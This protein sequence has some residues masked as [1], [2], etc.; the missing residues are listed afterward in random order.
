MGLILATATLALL[1]L[2]ILVAVTLHDLRSADLLADA[3]LHEPLRIYSSDGLLIGEYGVERRHYTDLATMPPCLVQAFLAAEDSR[4]FQHE[5]IDV[6]GLARAALSYLRTGEPTQGGSTITMQMVRNVYLTSEKTFDRK[7]AEILLAWHLERTLTK[8]EILAIYLNK[9]FFGHRAYGVAA[10]AQ[11]YYDKPLAELTLAEAAMLAGIPKAPSTNNPVTNPERALVR[12]DYVLGRMLALGDIDEEAYREARESPDRTRLHRRELG[13]EAGY[14]AEMARQEMVRRYG[15]EA[16]RAGYRVTTSIDSAH[17]RSA[18]AAV[19]DALLAY[20]RRHGYR[21]PERRVDL[22]EAAGED[23]DVLI[24]KALGE[25]GPI[26]GLTAAVVLQVQRD[27]AQVSIGH[28]QRLEL[29][30]EAIRWARPFRD[31]DRRGPA[32]KAVTDVLTVGDLIRLERTEA[33]AWMLAQRSRVS[34]ALVSVS[35]LDGAILALVGGSA[36]EESQFNRAS[37]ARRPAGSSFKPFLYAAA[38]ERGWTPA[39][40]VRD[41]SVAVR[42]SAR[43]VWRPGNADGKT[44]G[45]IRLRPALVQSRNLAAIDLLDQIGLD[46]AI[47]FVGRFGFD[48][49]RMPRGLSLALGSAEVSP[50]KMA[51]A[52][53]VFANGGYWVVPHLIRRIEGP[54]GHLLFEADPVRACQG[55]WFREPDADPRLDALPRGREAERVIS[56]PVAYQMHSMLADVI[57]NGTGRRARALK[58]ADIAGKTGTT[59]AVRDSWFC[60]YQKD[61]ATA[62]W[63]G[64]D[65]FSPLGRDE[66][67]GQ[68]AIEM[69]MAFMRHALAGRPDAILEVPAGMVQVR[70]DSASGERASATDR[71]VVLEWLSA[72]QAERIPAPSPWA[73][74]EID[75]VTRIGVPS[76]IKQVY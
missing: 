1:V 58:R 21:G 35:P 40:L 17:Q 33:G 37:D 45:P 48:P 59:N 18:Q 10:A 16:Y 12:R 30:L 44:L 31:P 68:A 6:A 52:Y 66:T 27:R 28:G 9:I 71:D 39:S 69:W 56:A 74:I 7:L 49:Q 23:A 34:G 29:P 57:R 22:A 60:G 19:R 13:L 5:G 53:A 3:R 2:G 43:E 47:G 50:L 73:S 25:A 46:E 75:G 38:L 54:A 15:E 55:C 61:L 11:L 26:A 14:A 70:I 64:F 62:A 36:Y 67:G 72:E 51:G 65:D 76:M 32:P 4:F 20:E 63:I 42:L 41:E 24:H 8:D